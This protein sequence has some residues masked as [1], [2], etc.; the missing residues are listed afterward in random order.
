M[1]LTLPLP[2]IL[3]LRRRWRPS[4][5]CVSGRIHDHP[6]LGGDGEGYGWRRHRRRQRRE[7]RGEEGKRKGF[8]ETLAAKK[9]KFPNH[10]TRKM[11]LLLSA[12]RYD[13][14]QVTPHLAAASIRRAAVRGAEWRTAERRGGGM[15]GAATLTAAAAK[16]R[17]VVACYES[18]R[19][20]EGMCCNNVC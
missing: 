4:S 6:S 14:Q 5:T 1:C 16:F 18:A 15:W 9:S 2:A 11:P 20:K 3:G 17:V 13:I 19:H 12:P 7:G 10:R 8:D